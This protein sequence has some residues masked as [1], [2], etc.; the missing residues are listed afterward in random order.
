[1]VSAFK[2][3]K[4]WRERQKENW[5]LAHR[6]NC[7]AR[8]RMVAAAVTGGAEAGQPCRQGGVSKGMQ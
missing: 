2:E 6:D 4:V 8:F 5:S 1:M 3:L 7:W